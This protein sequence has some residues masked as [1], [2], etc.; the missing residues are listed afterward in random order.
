MLDS[1]GRKSRTMAPE[2]AESLSIEALSFLAQN[3][4]EFL[5]FL[6]LSGL[7]VGELRQAAQSQAFLAGV[8]DYILGNEKTLVA[9]AAHAGIAPDLVGAARCALAPAFGTSD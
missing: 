4:E 7:T 5:R 6:A 2:A 9:F 1:Y 3:E 8:L